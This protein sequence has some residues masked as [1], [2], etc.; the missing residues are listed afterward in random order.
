MKGKSVDLGGRRIIK[1]KRGR[2]TRGQS[3]KVKERDW[4]G[5]RRVKQMS[6]RGQIETKIVTGTD[7]PIVVK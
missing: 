2:V 3:R 7:R 4:N 6:K 1:K 5:I